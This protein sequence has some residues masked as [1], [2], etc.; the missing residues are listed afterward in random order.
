MFSMMTMSM[1]MLR[2]P[3]WAM[4][5]YHLFLHRRTRRLTWWVRWR[6]RAGHPLQLPEGHRRT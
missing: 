3:S 1:M 5:P 2:Y 6:H 4:E